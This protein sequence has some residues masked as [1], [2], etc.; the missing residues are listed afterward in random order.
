M[1]IFVAA[2]LGGLV[3]AAGSMVGRILI[4]AGVSLVTFTGINVLLSQVLADVVSH[5]NSLG[6]TFV[7]IFGVLKLGTCINILVSAVTARMTLNGLTSG[8]V[9]RWVTR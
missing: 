9:S 7:G 8:T 6:P 4:A 5:A 2:L 1:P 3:S